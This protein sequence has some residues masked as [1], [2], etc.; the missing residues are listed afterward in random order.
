MA[1][2]TP[3]IQRLPTPV[4]PPSR[5]RHVLGVNR[6]EERQRR[7]EKGREGRSLRHRLIDLVMDEVESLP[8]LTSP[9]KQRIR[10]NLG[11]FADRQPEQAAEQ[12]PPPPPTSEQTLAV[13][14]AD[15]A[16]PSTDAGS[17]HPADGVDAAHLAQQIQILLSLHSERATKISNYIHALMAVA[18]D[19][20]QVDLDI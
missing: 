19:S 8:D 2:Y 4:T 5:D 16:A 12:P 11:R 10:H 9:Q 18:P 7:E 3:P 13:L 14:T 6:I 20:H 17:P 1:F 15:V